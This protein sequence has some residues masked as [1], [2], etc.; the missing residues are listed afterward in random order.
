MRRLILFAG[1]L[2]LTSYFSFSHEAKTPC[3]STLPGCDNYFLNELYDTCDY[4][5]SHIRIPVIFHVIYQKD[6]QNIPTP[7]ILRELEDLKRDFLMQNKDI[8]EVLPN[9]RG[10]AANPDIEFYLAPFK[11]VGQ[12]DSGIIRIHQSEKGSPNEISPVRDFAHSLNVYIYRR[13]GDEG[14]HTLSRPWS[15]TTTDAIYVNWNEIGHGYRILTHETG[16]WLGLMHTFECK[17]KGKGDGIDDT[18]PQ[19]NSSDGGFVIKTNKPE[20]FGSNC[21]GGPAFYQNFMDYSFFRRI[22]TTDQVKRMRIVLSKKR[23]KL[24]ENK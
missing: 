2:S 23:P 20:N 12:P 10:L 3:Q 9:Y 8:N 16:H 6:I 14:A 7:L 21:N 5:R 22:F 17:C 18:P 1:I 13:K 15:D 4:S 19:R 11:D 24:L